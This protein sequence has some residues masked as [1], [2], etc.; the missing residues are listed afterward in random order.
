MNPLNNLE[1]IKSWF[2]QM[3]SRVAYDGH[4]PWYLWRNKVQGMVYVTMHAFIDKV[5]DSTC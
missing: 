5:A 4:Q 1:Y 3:I 2:M